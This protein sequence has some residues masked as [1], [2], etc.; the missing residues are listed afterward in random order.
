MTLPIR[1]QDLVDSV[2]RALQHISHTHPA[3]F[4]AHLAEAHAREASPAAR[5]AMTQILLNSRMAATDRRPICQDTGI[6]NV[7]L[8]VGMDARWSGFDDGLEDAVN[9][10]VR[11]AYRHPDNPLRASLVSDPLF[12]RPN[13]RDNTPAVIHAR[14]VPGDTLTVTVAAKGGG[15]ENK[16]RLAML[17]RATAW[18][19]GC[20]ARC[21]SWAPAGV[22][23]ILGIG[24][25]GTAEGH[26]AGQGKPDGTAGYAVA[27]RGAAGRSRADAGTGPARRAA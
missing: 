22:P 26:A 20:C 13:T 21:P 9:E 24:V 11:L 18:S 7:L 12:G 10:G 16:A 6:V 5:N 19:T 1:R 17:N 8:E 14:V 25:G 3:D 27:A 23:G 2:A 15:S 4:L